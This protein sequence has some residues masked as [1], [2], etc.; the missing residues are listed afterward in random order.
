MPITTDAAVTM[1]AIVIELT[2][3]VVRSG[4]SKSS[5]YQRSVKPCQMKLNLPVVSL[6]PNRIITRIG[7]D[8]QKMITIV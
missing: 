7:S 4:M 8:S 5:R 3:A 1:S 6:N 2:R